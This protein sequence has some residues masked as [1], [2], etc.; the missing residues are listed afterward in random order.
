MSEMTLGRIL[1]DL[2]AAG[3]ATAGFGLMFR[4]QTKSL[5]PGAVI[6][7][8]GYLIY[9]V[10]FLAGGSATV[11]SFAGALAVGLL[12]EAAARLLKGPA[13]VYATMGAIPLVPGAWL[14]RTMEHII[15]ADYGQATAVG[16]ETIM[17][18][19]AIAMALGCSTVLARMVLRR[20]RHRKTE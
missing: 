3:V 2:I 10:I 20:Q 8:V 18:A 7:G 6:G 9:D 13:I 12:A 1:F 4:T 11:A 14:Y 19:G 16:L 17:I 5:L 15:V